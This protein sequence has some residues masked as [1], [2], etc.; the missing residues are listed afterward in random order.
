VAATNGGDRVVERPEF[1][2]FV[3]ARSPALL[4]TARL[5]TGDWAS[6]EDLLQDTLATCWRRW[7]RIESNPEPYVRRVMVNAYLARSRRFWNRERATDVLPDTPVDDRSDQVAV[8]HE[9][10]AALRGLPGRQRAVVVLRFF[11]DLSEKETARALG[12]SVGTVKSQTSRALARLRVDEGLAAER[13][14]TEVS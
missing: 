13:P 6:A 11:D 4:R 7:S 10:E 5:L 9:V 12:V 14:T 3:A 2:A 8:A 1:S